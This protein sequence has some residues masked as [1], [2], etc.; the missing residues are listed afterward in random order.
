MKSQILMATTGSLIEKEML[1]DP[2]DITL[3][4]TAG[5]ASDIEHLVICSLRKLT[6]LFSSVDSQA[7]PCNPTD[8]DGVVDFTECDPVTGDSAAYTLKSRKSRLF[9]E[10][11]VDD[12]MIKFRFSAEGYQEWLQQHQKEISTNFIHMKGNYKFISKKRTG[13]LH[14]YLQCQRAGMLRERKSRSSIKIG[15]P[16]KLQ[17][18]TQTRPEP[19][20]GSQ[21]VYEVTYLYQHNHGDGCFSSVGIR[22]KSEAARTT[23]KNLILGGS[24]IST[25]MHQLTM[26]HNKFT[27]ILRQTGRFSRDDFITYDDIYNIWHK[28]IVSR[29]TKDDDPIISSAKQKTNL[30][31]LVVKNPATGLGIPV[32]FL[33]TDTQESSV[34]AGWLKGLRS[35][36]AVLFSS[37]DQVY[38]YTPDT[39]VTDQGN[40]EVLAIKNAFAGDNT[41][42]LFCAWH[43]HC[44]WESEVPS[45][46][47]GISHLPLGLRE[48]IKTKAVSELQSILQ[49][50]DLPKAQQGIQLYRQK[51]LGKW[52]DS[53]IEYLDKNY[54]G[55]AEGLDAVDTLKHWMTCYRQD[56]SYSHIDTNYIKSWH[57]ILERHF[58]RDREQICSDTANYIIARM[59]I[60]HFQ[61]K[62]NRSISEVGRITPAQDID[63]R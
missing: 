56:V 54:F 20:G 9:G 7:E 5:N 60:S 12:R 37:P 27:Q 24:A 11:G 57:N 36:M 61:Q 50:P 26:E 3:S 13:D 39:I 31:T 15:C 51:W 46:I 25:M 49:E 23:I 33:L 30:F 32:A 10:L 62:C 22:Q 40:V 44:A 58:F 43:V 53:L 21:I 14:I 59:A 47:C 28:I 18:V 34:L 19:D 4:E 55:S 16:A 8:G 38:S 2:T 52:Q 1:T 42:I 48:H 29:M 6:D 63:E 45:R 35:K 17:V 41:R